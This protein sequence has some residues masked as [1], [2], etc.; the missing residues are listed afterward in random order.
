MDMNPTFIDCMTRYGELHEAG[1]G[2][3]EEARAL[4]ATAFDCAPPEFLE[5]A[6]REAMALGLMPEQPDGYL[7][8]G[9]PVYRVDRMAERLGVTEREIEEA[10]AQSLAARE[11]A[12]LPVSRM[13]FTADAVQGV[14]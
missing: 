6:S 13:V 5:A 12:G 3:T 10:A 7:P 9:S 2:D 11:A 1:Q 14:Q 4:L 8:D